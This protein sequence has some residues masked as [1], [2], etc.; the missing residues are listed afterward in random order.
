MEWIQFEPRSCRVEQEE[1]QKK[2][3]KKR[4]TKANRKI[5]KENLQVDKK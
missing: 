5:N 3:G 1:E 4:E 2:K